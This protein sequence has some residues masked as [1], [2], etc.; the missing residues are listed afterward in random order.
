MKIGL[1]GF[2][3]VGHALARLFGGEE[4]LAIYDKFRRGY[5]SAAQRAAM[6]SQELVFVAVPTPE[7]P[8]GSADVSQVEDVVGWVQAPVCIKS[9]VPPGTTDML[10][11]KYRKLVCFSPEYVG[12]TA[13]HP[14]KYV[15]SH[16]FII[17]GGPR[18]AARLVLRAYQERLG[19]E[20][21]YLL[22]TAKTAE[23]AKYME[24]CFLAM[25]V[26][27]TNQFFDLARL[28]GIDFNELRELWLQ[29]PRISRSHTLVTAERGF[30]GRC[31]PKDL[32]AVVALARRLGG[33]PL[34]E[35]V[36]RYNR[37][38][39]A[40]AAVAVAEAAAGNGD[41]NGLGSRETVAA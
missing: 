39:R 25:K 4:Q 35:A 5:N 21:R 33:A 14:L 3:V 29:D 32:A 12:E 9:T 6:D 16:G 15:E 38:I 2:G 10:A 23:M 20:T 34:L 1:V 26:A 36:Q 19:P 31:L 13:W 28:L 18:E 24:N 41:V 27:F 8:D 11:H 37:E 7:A 17:A 30:G 22:T 40:Q